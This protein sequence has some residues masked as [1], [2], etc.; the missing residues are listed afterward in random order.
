MR[1]CCLC[2][3]IILAGS[4]VSNAQD[5]DLEFVLVDAL[6][7]QAIPDAHLFISNSSIGA[8]SDSQGKCKLNIPSSE[9]HSLI[10]SHVSYE[11]L[12]IEPENYPSLNKGS[13]IKMTSNGIDLN[14]VMVTAKRGSKWKRNFKRFKQTLLGDDIAASQCTI[15]NPEVLRF[16][17]KD[18]T[19]TASASELLRID[20]DYLGYE[21]LFW[22][23]SLIIQEDGSRFYKGMG[24]FN[25]K[26]KVLDNK[27]QK[28]R[29]KS[30]L[31]S[32]AHFLRSLLESPNSAS[33]QQKGYQV[34]IAL[35]DNGIFN[36]LAFPAPKDLYKADDIKG[37]YQLHFSE[38]LT[39]NHLDILQT[40]EGATVS[41]SGAEQQKFGSDRTQ[42]ISQRKEATISRIY[43]ISRYLLF[44]QNGNIINKSDVREYNYWA[45]QRL[46]TTLPIDYKVFE[47]T[48]EEERNLASETLDSLL[49]LKQLIG[50]DDAERVQ[51]L[52]TLEDHWSMAYAAPLLEIL[53]LSND[54]W[55]QKEIKRLLLKKIPEITPKYFEGIQWV[56]DQEFVH[57]NFYAEFKAYIHS[58]LDNAFYKYF[59]GRSDQT[60]IRLDEIVWGGVAQD[61]IPPLRSPKMLAAKEAKYLAN[62]DVVFGLYLNGKAYAYPKR[63][64]A[65]HEFF[66][67]DLNGSSVAGVYCTLCGTLIVYDA[68]YNGEKH[69][70]G[71]SGFLYRSNKLM[72]D[73]ATQSLWSTIQGRPVVGP[74]IDSE[75]ELKT[76]PVETTTYG[77][78]LNKHPNTEVLSLET[79][80][81]RNYDEGEAYKNYYADDALMFPTPIQD[82]RLANK[83]RVFIPRAEEFKEEPLALS[84]DYLKKKGLHQ[85]Q[86][87]KQNILVLTERNGASRVYAISEQKFKSYKRGM[88]S[89]QD[90][91]KWE[92]SDTAIIS[93]YGDRFQRL[94]AHEVFWFAWV[95]VYPKTRIIY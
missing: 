85:D 19:F 47:D 81:Q 56:W 15:L 69:E 71:T 48:E 20:N 33:L 39:V 75:I 76:L 40:S 25:E 52:K 64:L 94:P 89:D 77:A 54:G 44:D 34:A 60:K 41:I 82:N 36:N 93:P 17:E 1:W 32:P 10:I 28:R 86:I 12:V 38:F 9:N 53:R 90:G 27:R 55:Q 72:Y 43:K 65:W 88:L 13:I 5:L 11:T 30:Y 14:E 67:D 73:K 62:E 74:L 6:T 79:G 57:S 45:E 3:I 66:T 18:G 50:F 2:F 92:V 58:S 91:T 31:N 83:A 4:K 21:I 87:G 23:E 49:L 84:V 80:H 46:A 7:N 63:I 35:Y 16:E 42:S 70:L 24:Q 37:L 78:W 29:E 22:L 26:E 51:A 59:Q 68:S 95:N 8:T 61:G